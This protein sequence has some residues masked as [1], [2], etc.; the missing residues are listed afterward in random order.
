MTS[1]HPAVRLLIRALQLIG[2]LRSTIGSCSPDL[3]VKI[4]WW[5][6]TTSPHPFLS[7]F[8]LFF[9]FC[10]H[11]WKILSL[12][13][14]LSSMQNRTWE[15]SVH[16]HSVFNTLRPWHH[17]VF[18]FFFNFILDKESGTR[19]WR[20]WEQ[21]YNMNASSFCWTDGFLAAL[22]LCL[23]WW[24]A[25]KCCRYGDIIIT[26]WTLALLVIDEGCI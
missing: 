20:A 7:P 14:A 24:S 2:S 13:A 16:F 25:N 5:V 11:M 19:L 6:W 15:T 8:R 12:Y 10:L 21:N 22:L 18:F 1:Y 4:Y 23:F 9:F 26:S 17:G 3:D